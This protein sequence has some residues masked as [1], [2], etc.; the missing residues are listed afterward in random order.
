VLPTYH[1]AYLLRNPSALEAWWLDLK[2]AFRI[3]YGAEP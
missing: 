2:Q 3:A 1:P